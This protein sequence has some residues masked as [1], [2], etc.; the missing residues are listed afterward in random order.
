[1]NATLDF[2]KV[3]AAAVKKMTLSI[4]KTLQQFMPDADWACAKFTNSYYIEDWGKYKGIAIDWTIRISD[5]AKPGEKADNYIKC[6]N[7]TIEIEVFNAE[8]AKAAKDAIVKYFNS[9]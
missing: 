5:H 1:M 7:T 2:T 4:L 8:G 6:A 9:L 3:P